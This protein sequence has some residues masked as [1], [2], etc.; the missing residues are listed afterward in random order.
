MKKFGVRDQVGYMLG[1]I[2]GSFVNLY[3]GSFFIIFCT[4]VLGVSPYFMGTM[5]LVG[6][7][8]DAII[9]AIMGTLPD[10][11]R[12]GTSGDKFKPWINFSKWLLAA[13][14][15][16]AFAN[17]SNWE[18]TFI[19]IW[20]VAAYL[21]FC[22]A[23]T[24]DAIPYGSLASVITNDPVERTKLSRAR[25]IGGM[26]V[27]VGFLSFV[28]M[29]I[30][31]KSG[32]IV[33]EAFFYIAIAFS[34]LSLLSYTLLLKLTTERIRDDR[35]AGQKSDYDFK[36][37]FKAAFTNRPLIG[38]MV[39]TL[40]SMFIVA[41]IGTLAP[42]VFAEYFDAPGAFAI[43]QFISMGLTLILFVFIPKLVAKFNKRN[44]I[45]VTSSFSLIA[46]VLMTFITF[47]NV[48]VFAVLY[49]IATI[50]SAVFIMLVWALVT[51]C[52]D[53]TEYNTGKH[54]EG[55]LYS[56]YSF[57]RKVGM[58]IGA[59]FGSYALGWVGFVSGAKSQTQEVAE[60][61]LKMYTA[62]PIAA[63]ILIL[64]G[65]GLIFHLNTKRTNE[66]YKALKE[67]R[68]S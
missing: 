24:A 59:A 58:G 42:I 4:Y 13:S 63:F 55:T 64:I 31:D 12:I 40:G 27:G 7:V 38:M 5:F 41:G 3:I 30:Y 28:P 52:I 32:N 19:H 61:V 43:N 54:Y 46:S 16:L 39:A 62:L 53:Y 33:P 49:N 60:G 50:G 21:F 45:I 22:I 2:G 23:Y 35:P 67:R 29:V 10:R 44:L 8:F 15:L 65:V 25:S 68:A 66:M 37:A 11:F 20:V 57:V 9:T 6:K 48:Y 17:V 47:G 18:S 51:D 36:D 26:I 1:D 34:I 14:C 56:L